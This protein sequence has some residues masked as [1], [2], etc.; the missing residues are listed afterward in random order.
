MLAVVVGH[1]AKTFNRTIVELKLRIRKMEHL[2]PQS[3]NRT[4]VELKLTCSIA[5]NSEGIL[6]IEPLWN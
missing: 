5:T 2:N 1:H 6:L 3:F 4:I